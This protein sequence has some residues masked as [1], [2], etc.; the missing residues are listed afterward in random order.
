M[1]SPLSPIKYK[2]IQR[3]NFNIENIIYKSKR[4][5]KIDKSDKSD[6]SIL[7]LKRNLVKLKYYY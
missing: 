3:I 7:K 1:N 6:K 2:N 4:I 5:L